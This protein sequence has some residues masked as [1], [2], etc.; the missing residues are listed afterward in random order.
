[1]IANKTTA[2]FRNMIFVFENMEMRSKLDKN[3]TKMFIYT[4]K[5]G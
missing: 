2:A 3:E 1:M 4:I 5:I